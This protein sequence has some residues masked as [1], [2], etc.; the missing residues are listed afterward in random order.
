VAAL[1]SFGLLFAGGSKEITSRDLKSATLAHISSEAEILKFGGESFFLVKEGQAVPLG[2][3][4]VQAVRVPIERAAVLS[5]EFLPFIEALDA[6]HSIY[7]LSSF[8]CVISERI[9]EQVKS[10]IVA[11][12]GKTSDLSFSGL[13]ESRP[14]IIFTGPEFPEDLKSLMIPVF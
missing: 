3:P 1:F 2:Y 5:R 7:A 10:G 4:E 14:Q 6:A 11:E 9:A 8:D 13:Q 12:L